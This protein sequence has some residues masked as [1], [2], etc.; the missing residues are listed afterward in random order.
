MHFE[1]LVEEFS[2]K[3]CLEQLLP[4]IL[5]Q[6]ITYKIHNFRGK[7]DLLKKLP[8]RLKGYKN[9]MPDDYRIIIL[10]D[11]DN[12]DCR[13]LKDQLED[14]AKQTGLI[15]KS[16]SQD[17]KTFQV[18]N[19]I[20]IEELEAW[21]FGHVNAIVSAY[22]KV[23]P[24]LGQQKKYR[25]PDEI[26]GGTWEALEKVLQKYGYHKG[27]LEKVKAAREISK[28]MTPQNNCSPSFQ[29]FYQGILEMIEQ[30]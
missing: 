7:S 29:V 19:R 20:A 30:K 13:I 17:K 3:E 23:S 12:E 24:N 11:R 4:K 25:K 27:G 22:S 8:N 5:S 2:A 10:V 1:F 15:T 9:W 16:I 6:S 14:I 28:F 18:L 26:T 21:F